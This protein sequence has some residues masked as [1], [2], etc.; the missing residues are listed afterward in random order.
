VVE[1]GNR[2][3]AADVDNDVT[4]STPAGPDGTSSPGATLPAESVLDRRYRLLTLVGSRGPVTL[5]RGDD[6][7]LARPV[8]VRVVEHAAEDSDRERAARMLLAAAVNS[9]RLVHPGAASTYDATVTTAE[10]GRVS[11]VVAEWVDGKTLR[12]LATEGP[13]RPEKAGAVVLGAARVIA[14][15]HE[16]G[17]HHGDLHPGEVIVSGH[18]TVKVINLEV[19]AVL[20]ALD[21]GRPAHDGA[22][23]ADDRPAPDDES[24][25]RTAEEPEPTRVTAEADDVRALGALLYAGLTGHW[26]LPGDRGL[27]PAPTGPHGRVR[28]PRQ[29]RPDIPRDLD[30]IT[31]ATLAGD[32]TAGAPI[33]TAGEFVAELEAVTPVEAV[34]DTGLMSFGDGPM[35]TEAMATSD[36]GAGGPPT[37]G[38]GATAD[39]G[40]TSG[41]PS[42]SGYVEPADYPPGPRRSQPGY[43]DAGYPPAG[44]GRRPPVQHGG[45]RG[46][47]PAPGRRS[48]GWTARLPWVAL[49]VAV[50]LVAV[51]AVVLTRDKD[52]GATPGSSPAPTVSAG[53]PITNFTVGSFDPQGQGDRLENP[54]KVRLATDG[55]P[56]TAWDTEGYNTQQ[57][58]GLKQGV[59][60]RFE[61]SGP[62]RPSQVSVT[63]GSLGPVVFEL[64]AGDVSGNDIN[65]Y[66]TVGQPQTGSAG[67]TVAVSVPAG[68][69]AHRYWVLWLT[70][71]P[72]GQDGRFKGSIA[73]V[74]FRS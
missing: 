8:A 3:Q 34:H 10:T 5:W 15:A 4:T 14:A 58:G 40:P 74:Q 37:A 23:G 54:G 6:N 64:R 66:Q 38:Y 49:A 67:G 45:A 51:A 27:P 19:G 56:G 2:P 61:F 44:P 13:L 65:A 35:D 29:V 18:G 12:Q 25:G 53:S 24:A 7:V 57:F 11:Y 22:A 52:K 70:Q 55:N 50:A 17:I 1:G 39:F 68:A 28:T 47:R 20:A 33:T 46:A 31:V 72:P 42:T 16:R 59:G 71:L 48:A 21:G 69:A 26:P 9:G 36:Y 43:P 63:M 73:E 32:G 62:V 30:A 60:L 41:Y